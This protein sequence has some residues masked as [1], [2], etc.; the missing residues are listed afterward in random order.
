MCPSIFKKEAKFV[1]YREQFAIEVLGFFSISMFSILQP[2]RQISTVILVGPGSAVGFDNIII[3]HAL[4]F[5]FI[6]KTFL[7]LIDKTLFFFFFV[8]I[9]IFGRGVNLFWFCNKVKNIKVKYKCRCKLC[10]C[11]WSFLWS[12]NIQM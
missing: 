11:K 6:M 9:L 1:A 7:V 5:P 12:K 8:K 2:S 10:K 3:G 4:Q